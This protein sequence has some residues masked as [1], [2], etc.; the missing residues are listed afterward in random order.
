ME[1]ELGMYECIMLICYTVLGGRGMF[2]L[3]RFV[4]SCCYY[5][6]HICLYDFDLKGRSLGLGL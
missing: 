6:L 4:G 1:C 2:R 3:L 5:L